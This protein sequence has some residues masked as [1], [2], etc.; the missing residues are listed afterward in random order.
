MS[1]RFSDSI[2]VHSEGEIQ[3]FMGITF[4]AIFH[5]VRN[6]YKGH[7]HCSELH[8]AVLQSRNEADQ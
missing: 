2:L 6:T 8:L 4:F 1:H 5:L 3:G 7:A